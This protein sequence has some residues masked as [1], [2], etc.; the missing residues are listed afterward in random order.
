MRG[1]KPPSYF[2]SSPNVYQQIQVAQSESK[3]VESSRKRPRPP[4]KCW[5]CKG[6]HLY[7]DFPHKEDKMRIVHNLQEATTVEYVGRNIPRIYASLEDRQEEHQSHMIEVEGKITNQPVVILIDSG[8][9]HSYIDPK[10]VDIFH[11]KKSNLERSCL[12]QL[13]TG[14]KRRINE[15]VRSCPIDLNG[16]NTI[17]DL[18]II[19]LG[20]YDI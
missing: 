19:P 4:I 11:L 16:V 7:R 18:N 20:S 1:F 10:L 12:V 5:G 2:R 3:M 15:V 14:T 9:S 8:A 6:E 17:V 13:A